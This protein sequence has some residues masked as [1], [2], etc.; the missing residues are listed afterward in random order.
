MA[1]TQRSAA[2]LLAP[3]KGVLVADEYVGAMLEP[4]GV[5]RSVRTLDQY[6]D[7][8]LATPRLTDWV[9]GVLLTA[10]TFS[11]VARPGATAE[12]HAR[13]I[14]LGVRMDIG[15]ARPQAGFDAARTQ[16]AGVREAG[17]TFVEWRANLDPT[18]VAPGSSHVDAEALALGAAAAQGEQILPLLTIAMPD[19]ASHTAAVSQ[20]VTGNALEELFAQL[21]RS[22]IDTSAV[23]LRLNMVVAGDRNPEQA[24]PEDVA[25]A[26]LAVISQ[27]VPADVPGIL[28]L[29][30]RQQLDQ[31]CANLAAI[32]SLARELDHPARFTFGFARTLVA[33][34]LAA[35]RDDADHAD[36]AA[37]QQ[38]LADS[39]ALAAQSSAVPGPSS[40]APPPSA[41]P[42]VSSSVPASST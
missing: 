2:S 18:Q 5:Q 17:A 15:L 10:D 26:T 20:A 21:A 16:L 33:G 40:S 13:D 25:R 3:G 42:S 34:S 14:Q 22:G 1:Q 38:A 4:G 24:T 30:G 12:G 39:C 6:V 8:A 35:W 32:A 28:F 19:L 31:A 37:V 29:S 7:L 9:S 11:A 27:S 36:D 41:P 23:L